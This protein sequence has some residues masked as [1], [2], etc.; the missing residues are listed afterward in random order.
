LSLTGIPIEIGR[1]SMA[2]AITIL[3]VNIIRI[4][5]WENMRKIQRLT[6]QQVSIQQ[7][8]DL[9]RELHDGI[10]QHMF[11]TGLKLEEVISQETNPEKQAQLEIVKEGLNWSMDQL[12]TFI[13]Q[14]PGEYIQVEDLRK[15]LQSL[16]EGFEQ[17][18][19]LSVKLVDQIP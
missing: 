18:W 17:N 15:S 2:V 14:K 10:V 1:A 4:F 13:D 19:D 7:R 16:A 11:V 8:N 5:E 9:G 3:V 12:R 6:L